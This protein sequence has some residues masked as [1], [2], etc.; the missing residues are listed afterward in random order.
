MLQSVAVSWLKCT[1]VSGL[2]VNNFYIFPIYLY[3]IYKQYN[4][5][6]KLG[7]KKER[8]LSSTYNCNLTSPD[9]NIFCWSSIGSFSA[10]C[11]K[12]NSFP[13]PIFSLKLN[14][15]I[16]FWAA[17][18][19]CPLRTGYACLCMADCTFQFR[20]LQ[21]RQLYIRRQSLCST[22]RIKKLSCRRDAARCFV[23]VCSQLQHT[24]SAVLYY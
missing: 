6:N 5:S 3:I 23:F 1:S 12:P 18:E 2:L 24:Y 15:I 7:N 4:I 16:Y 8:E 21:T 17:G 9:V 13:I 20:D 22:E 11:L 10:K 19:L 14:I